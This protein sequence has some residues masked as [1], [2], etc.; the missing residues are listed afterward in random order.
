MLHVWCGMSEDLPSDRNI[1]DTSDISRW[2]VSPFLTKVLV[3]RTLWKRVMHSECYKHYFLQIATFFILMR[4]RLLPVPVSKRIVCAKLCMKWRRNME[5][6]LFG[7][8]MIIGRQCEGKWKQSSY[9]AS[10][11]M[12]PWSLMCFANTSCSSFLALYRSSR[13]QLW[14]PL[15][16]S[17]EAGQRYL[18]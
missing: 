13:S 2:V 18:S 3:C 7:N 1:K 11:C 12:D 6:S 15:L 16:V 4:R 8:L 10:W 17:W 14:N 5:T 9:L